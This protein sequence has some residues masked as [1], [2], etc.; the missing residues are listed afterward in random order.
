MNTHSIN[1]LFKKY[2]LLNEENESKIGNI[3]Q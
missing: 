3:A 2:K 1:E